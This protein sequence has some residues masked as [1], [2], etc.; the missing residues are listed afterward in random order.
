MDNTGI[1]ITVVVVAII[2][3]IIWVLLLRSARR[4]NLTSTSGDQKPE[5]M[6]T[7]PQPETI[8]ATQADGEGMGLYDYDKGESVAAPFAEQIEDV[9]RHQMSA[10]PYLRS[11]DVDFGT[12]SDGGL[13]IKVGDK[14]YKAIEQIPDVRLREALRQAVDTYNQRK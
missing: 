6:R 3:L 4:V 8:A 7:D 12:G 9:L 5:W 11:L 13:E 1:I 2:M 10:D 14:V